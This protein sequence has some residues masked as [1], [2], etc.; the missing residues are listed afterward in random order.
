[1]IKQRARSE[2]NTAHLR[3]MPETVHPVAGDA[4]KLLTPKQQWRYQTQK[5]LILKFLRTFYGTLKSEISK[6]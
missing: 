2:T 4:L 6:L 3:D 5:L 1:V